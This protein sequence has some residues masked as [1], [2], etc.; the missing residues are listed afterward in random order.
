[1]GPGSATD[2]TIFPSADVEQFLS[3]IRR[4]KR[5]HREDG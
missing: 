2:L 3:L 5:E 1:M 4:S